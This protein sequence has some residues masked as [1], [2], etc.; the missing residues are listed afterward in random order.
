MRILMFIAVCLAASSL[1]IGFQQADPGDSELVVILPPAD[2]EGHI[3]NDVT[4]LGL[5][6]YNCH[7]TRFHSDVMEKFTGLAIEFSQTAES[8]E[9][10]LPGDDIQLLLKDFTQSRWSEIGSEV[11]LISMS[12]GLDST[13]DWMLFSQSA[14]AQI[15]Q[16]IAAGDNNWPAMGIMVADQAVAMA[17]ASH[18]KVWERFGRRVGQA[19]ERGTLEQWSQWGLQVGMQA[20]F[21]TRGMEIDWNAFAADVATQAR[22]FESKLQLRKAGD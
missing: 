4:M 2:V 22:W 16:R 11:G 9:D 5:A 15:V 13:I 10:S 19:V 12:N 14:G 17:K 7:W 8:L 3:L 18:D 1:A 6:E 20:R 21:Q